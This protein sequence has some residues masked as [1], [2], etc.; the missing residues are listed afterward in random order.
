MSQNFAIERSA[1]SKFS[2]SLVFVGAVLGLSFIMVSISYGQEDVPEIIRQAEVVV[3]PEP[4]P[5]QAASEEIVFDNSPGVVEEEEAEP[6][7]IAGP[8][9]ALPVD[10]IAE[11]EPL[12]E[13]MEGNLTL[14]LRN[15]DVTDAMKFLE[16]GR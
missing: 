8:L 1:M 15:I 9:E 10:S 4:A 7:E 16:I 11:V 12:P 3:V 6:E 14:D 5:Q 2:L 13:G